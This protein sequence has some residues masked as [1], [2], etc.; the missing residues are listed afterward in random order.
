L[1]ARPVRGHHRHMAQHWTS[2]MTRTALKFGRVF[3]AQS[4]PGGGF[5]IAEADSDAR[6]MRIELD[7]IRARFADH[8]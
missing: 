3:R 2:P 5:E 1:M 4:R 8:A 7:A 6:R